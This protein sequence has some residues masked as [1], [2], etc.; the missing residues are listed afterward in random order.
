MY[1]FFVFL[2]LLV[3]TGVTSCKSSPSVFGIENRVC[4]LRSSQQLGSVFGK[5]CVF[6]SGPL[7]ASHIDDFRVMDQNSLLMVS[8]SFETYGVGE[9]RKL[10]KVDTALFSTE[11][12]LHSD[13]DR[14][15]PVAM[16]NVVNQKVAVASLMTPGSLEKQLYSEVEILIYDLSFRKIIHQAALRN[17][18]QNDAHS[19]EVFQG[20]SLEYP[21]QLRMDSQGNVHVLVR[22]R[23]FRIQ[24]LQLT[25]D[26]NLISHFP[27]LTVCS[28]LKTCLNEHLVYERIPSGHSIVGMKLHLSEMRD[29]ENL[30]HVSIGTDSTSV[31]MIFNDKGEM[32][33]FVPFPLG[34]VFSS[35]Q[36]NAGL[37]AV[38][39][40]Q[41]LA[42][43][44]Q[45][46]ATIALYGVRSQQSAQHDSVLNLDLRWEHRFPAESLLSSVGMAAVPFADGKVIFGGRRGFEQVSCNPVKHFLQSIVLRGS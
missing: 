22:S 14:K 11:D 19:T 39:G 20:I 23:E 46:D 15:W 44:H 21:I 12:L 2:L 40:M 30:F 8:G 25:S 45:R 26:L 9:V 31:L 6:H 33:N 42:V 3:A 43:S 24:L 5:Q 17:L 41:S 37:L 16:S 10:Q 13:R 1:L 29:I 4:Q 28:P 7:F 18:L 36:L 34:T 38:A 35:I 27:I 32:E